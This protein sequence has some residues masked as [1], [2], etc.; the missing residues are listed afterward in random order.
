MPTHT[1]SQ[2]NDL[3]NQQKAGWLESMQN[4]LLNTFS[5]SETLLINEKANQ[6]KEDGKDIFKFGFGQSPFPIPQLLQESLRENVHQKA[7]LPVQGLLELREQV[8]NHTNSLLPKTH[9]TADQVFIGP[10]SKELI[11]LIQYALD[12]PLILPAPS[13]VSYV[14]QAKLLKRE[15]HSI[16]TPINHWKLRAEDLQLYLRENQIKRGLLLLNY[17]NNPTGLTYAPEELMAIARI[18]REH[19]IL[20]L[21]DEIYGLLNFSGQYHSIASYYP[22]GTIL[23]TGISKWCGAGG[24]R[25]GVV[26]IPLPIK[27]LLDPLRILA[28]ETFSSVCAPVQYAAITA[29]QPLEELSIYRQNCLTVL[30]TIAKYCAD[31]L[32]GAGI[33]T[34]PAEGG[35]YLFPNFGRNVKMK[36]ALK[37]GPSLCQ[38]I[39]EETGVMLL[40]GSSFGRPV[41]EL[42]ARLCFVD[43]DGGTALHY[44]TK[45][46]G[47][48][49]PKDFSIIFPRMKE[50]IARLVDWYKHSGLSNDL[51]NP[52]HSYP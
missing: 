25:L 4:P 23:S 50:G 15:I 36:G 7:Y 51:V 28:S 33:I 24:W 10:G 49:H 14:P 17:P 9:W 26:L 21:A 20:I 43:F 37:T 12:L 3:Q 13:W 5:A 48:L 44:L 47:H 40:P 38:R 1:F 41:S 6:L 32:N 42:T 18:C 45:Q 46:N 31:Q 30:Q 35:F 8:A 39:L 34:L 16:P 27:K 22:E 19:D 2:P 52:N 11:F 29:Y